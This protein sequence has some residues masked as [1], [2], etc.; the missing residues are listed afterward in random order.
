MELPEAPLRESQHKHP[1]PRS[2][3]TSS[4]TGEHTPSEKTHDILLD[5]G[6]DRMPEHGSP[7]DHESR[8]AQ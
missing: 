4:A 8:T 7:H 3:A 1:E 2:K 6:R 5:M